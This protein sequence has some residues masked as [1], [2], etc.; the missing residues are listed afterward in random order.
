LRLEWGSRCMGLGKT[1]VPGG[2]CPSRRG[3]VVPAHSGAAHRLLELNV[4]AAV[5]VSCPQ[6]FWAPHVQTPGFGALKV[7]GTILPHYPGVMPKCLDA[8]HGKSEA[9]VSIYFVNGAGQVR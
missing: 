3:G 8:C 2:D 4:D 6:I 5:S 1:S 9:G 7:H